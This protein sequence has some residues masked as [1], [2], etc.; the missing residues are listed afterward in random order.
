MSVSPGGRLIYFSRQHGCVDDVYSVA[1]SGG[2]PVL[3]TSGSLPAV[4]PDGTSLAIDRQPVLSAAA[5][6]PATRRCS[7]AW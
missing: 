6:P 1:A 2:Q 7:T 3:I 5:A 4:S